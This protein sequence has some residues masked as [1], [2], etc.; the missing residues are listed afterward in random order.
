MGPLLFLAQRPAV[1][2]AGIVAGGT[3]GVAGCFGFGMLPE[4]EG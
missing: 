4:E 2:A 3:P 1:A